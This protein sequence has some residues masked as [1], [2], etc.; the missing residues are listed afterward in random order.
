MLWHVV[1]VSCRYIK[2]G[3]YGLYGYIGHKHIYARILLVMLIFLP[4]RQF[5]VD[6]IIKRAHFSVVVIVVTHSSIR[7]IHF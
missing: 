6:E 7:Q 1:A 2:Y 4:I 5:L 3:I